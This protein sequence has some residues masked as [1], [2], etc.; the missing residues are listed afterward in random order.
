VEPLKLYKKRIKD[1]ELVEIGYQN[2]QGWKLHQME[3]TPRF[4]ADFLQKRGLLTF[5]SYY[6][7]TYTGDNGNLKICV[8]N[9]PQELCINESE[10]IGFFIGEN[11]Y[12]YDDFTHPT[13][14]KTYD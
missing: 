14:K 4:M 1:D 3:P 2:P 10:V 8:S 12:Y 9:F 7:G 13:T 11:Y 5:S 6:P